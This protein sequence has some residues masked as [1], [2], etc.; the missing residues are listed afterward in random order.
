MSNYTLIRTNDIADSQVTTAKIADANVTTAKIADSNVTTV[1]IADANVITSKIA[2]ANVTTA[3]IADSAV[4]TAKIADDNVTKAKIN[5]DVPGIAMSQ[6]AG[7]E[8]DVNVDGSTINVN[9]SDQLQVPA[10][11]ITATQIAANAVGASELADD[12][13]DT[14]AIQDDAVTNAKIAADAIERSQIADDAV[15]PDELDLAGNYNFEGTS[16]V[17]FASGGSASWATA[18]T[19]PNHLANKAYVDS[20]S[21]GLSWKN[22]VRAATTGNITLSGAQTIDGVSISDGDRVLVKDQTAGEENGI[23]VAATGAWS[24][25]SDMDAAS[26]FPSAAVFVSEGTANADLGFTCTNDS[27]TVGTTAIDFVEFT[28]AYNVTAG[29]GL[30]KSGNTL[31]VNAGLGIVIDSDTVATRLAGSG[32]L[33]NDQGTGSDELAIKVHQGVQT[34]SNGLSA[35][36]EAASG[37]AFGSGDGLELVP[38]GSKAIEIDGAGIAV[39]INTDS[40]EFDAGTGAIDVKDLGINTA[41]LANNAVTAAKIA[42]DAIEERHLSNA[43]LALMKGYTNTSSFVLTG[44]QTNIAL[45]TDCPTTMPGHLFFLNGRLMEIGASKD[46][47]VSGG[48]FVLNE[49]GVAGDTVLV[50][51]DATA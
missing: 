45:P 4:V 1:K 25:A 16:A 23:Y 30:S 43:V 41:E 5:A 31:N 35:K 18:P 15:G 11:G 40:L 26:E 38:N 36:F 21:A 14:A 24:R 6:A 28:G 7:G 39:K 46:Y 8:L 32:G 48:N 27:V 42:D 17:A 12:A 44:G 29:D 3:K 2:D 19:S 51:F 49:A 20:L 34:S 10:D 22:A 13:V 37:L 33:L 50:V 9:G 47:Q